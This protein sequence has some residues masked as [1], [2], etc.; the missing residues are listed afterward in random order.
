MV[1]T[2]DTCEGWMT[3]WL[4]APA[5]GQNFKHDI[6]KES[7]FW[8]CHVCKSL[9]FEQIFLKKSAIISWEPFVWFC[10]EVWLMFPM[11]ENFLSSWGTF[12][13]KH[14]WSKH[15]M[16]SNLSL[17]LCMRV[18]TRVSTWS[19]G[20]LLVFFLDLLSPTLLL[21]CHFVR[22]VTGKH[23]SGYVK[24]VINNP[25]QFPQGQLNCGVLPL[26]WKVLQCLYHP[27][28]NT[29]WGVET[30]GATNPTNRFA[31]K[32]CRYLE[33]VL[34]GLISVQISLLS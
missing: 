34:N 18:C 23:L 21:P 13:I 1:G 25:T 14:F 15:M 30:L 9:E 10:E 3:K 11:V 27:F 32:T 28:Q 16:K 26:F 7:S 17:R 22:I 12:L 19:R 8:N 4:S 24:L 33:E 20:R 6:L 2:Q 5:L 29:Q 31:T